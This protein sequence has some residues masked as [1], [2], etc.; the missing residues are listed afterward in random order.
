MPI[1]ITRRPPVITREARL[2]VIT[3]CHHCPHIK[4]VRT[5]GAGCAEDFYCTA[6]T[7]PAMVVGY[8]EWNKDKRPDHN[9]PEWCPLEK[10]S[11]P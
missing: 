10:R 4:N 5:P 2:V 6:V 1:K 7:P 9:F 11:V 8:V 3:N